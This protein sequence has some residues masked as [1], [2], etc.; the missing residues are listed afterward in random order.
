[1][2]PIGHYS[3]TGIQ[4]VDSLLRLK[5][6]IGRVKD[7]HWSIRISEIQYLTLRQ[8]KSNFKANHNIDNF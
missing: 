6:A 2:G 4:N 3:R 8:C 5:L 7:I 1:M